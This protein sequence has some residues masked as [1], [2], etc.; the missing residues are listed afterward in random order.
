MIIEKLQPEYL[1]Q[2]IALQQQIVPYRIDPDAAAKLYE[3]MQHRSDCMVLCA[4]EGNTVIGTVSGFCCYGLGGSF[5]A[6]EDLIVSEALRGGGI[7][8][9]LMA[10]IEAFGRE[11][12]CDYAILVSSGFRK[13][14]HHFY[15]KI[16]YTEDVR[17]FR[18][19][20]QA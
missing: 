13:R 14:A 9:Q 1:P 7:G 10:A 18:R 3:T 5:L 19:D 11:Q 12:G 2:L 6:I 20:L 16:G 15:E 17:G 8:T 4:R